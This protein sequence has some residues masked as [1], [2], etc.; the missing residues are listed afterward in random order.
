MKHV[1]EIITKG[2]FGFWEVFFSQHVGFILLDV[3]LIVMAIVLY[4]RGH[5]KDAQMKNFLGF[6]HRS[7]ALGPI[8]VLLT[9]GIIIYIGTYTKMTTD[10]EDK[11]AI[12]YIESLPEQSSEVSIVQSGNLYHV[13][14]TK[15]DKTIVDLE[16]WNDEFTMKET[17]DT[18]PKAT[19]SELHQN[20][21]H[22]FKEGVYGVTV[23]LPK[24]YEIQQV[25][26]DNDDD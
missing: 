24:G 16:L 2:E 15:S 9:I 23:F 21:G 7:F 14:V 5:K 8:I 10:W 18:T 25:E 20:L 1:N 13:K 17:D 11:Y 19:F 26:I 22:G 6:F 12:P 3:L 4:I